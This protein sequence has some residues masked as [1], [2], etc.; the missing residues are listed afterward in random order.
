MYV[1]DRPGQVCYE[2]TQAHACFVSSDGCGRE[3][4][5]HL[6]LLGPVR[7]IDVYVQS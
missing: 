5:T 7:L 3:I 1:S 4:D 6:K 2:I